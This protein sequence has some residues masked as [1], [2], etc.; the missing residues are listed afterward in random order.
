MY[1]DKA[2]CINILCQVNSFLMQC[3]EAFNNRQNFT[4]YIK[5]ALSWLISIVFF[6]QN[7]MLC[8]GQNVKQSVCSK[9]PQHLGFFFFRFPCRRKHLSWVPIPSSLHGNQRLPVQRRTAHA[10][11]HRPW[12]WKTTDFLGRN[13]QQQ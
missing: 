1:F 9:S 8:N 3:I 10:P 11:I 5:C 12:I 6:S 4:L 7:M 2:F 13:S